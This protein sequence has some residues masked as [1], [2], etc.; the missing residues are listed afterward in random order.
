MYLRKS[1][2]L[3][4]L[5]LLPCL[6]GIAQPAITVTGPAVPALRDG[7]V[8]W[9]DY[10]G[11]GLQDLLVCGRDTSEVRRTLLLHNSGMSMDIDTSQQLVALSSGDAAWADMDGDGDPDLVLTGETAPRQEVTLVYRNNGG[12]LALQATTSL[13]GLS[14]GRARWADLD[15]DGDSDLFLTGFN[16]MAGFKGIIGRNDGGG[17]FTAVENPA[18]ATRDWTAVGIGDIDG[19][20]LPDIAFS[21]VSPRLSEG[22]RTVVLRNNGGLH[23]ST[24][25]SPVPGMY[26]GSMEFGDWDG[27]GDRDLLASGFG[28]KPQTGIYKYHSGQY[29]VTG[30]TLMEVGS[31]EARW[32]DLDVDGDL[33]VVVSGMSMAGPQTRVYL[34]SGGILSLVQGPS[35][36]PTLHQVRMAF[37]DWNGD[38]HSDMAIMG[39]NENGDPETY[40]A[41]WN[42]ALQQF[43]F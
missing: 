34:N 38:G 31:G 6:W 5:L 27:D 36:M 13:P 43:K 32:V 16:T 3:L 12:N 33:D 19:N 20:G 40:I 8:A 42:N 25:P 21:D 41:T 35:N 1:I 18:Y 4:A 30:I 9:A 2:H 22:M 23:F 15:G 14:M 7:A 24:L 26:G 39:Q 37:A 28:T 17:V 29:L 11:D 10:D